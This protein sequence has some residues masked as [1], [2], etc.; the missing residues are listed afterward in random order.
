MVH[1]TLSIQ[2]EGGT[3]KYLGLPELFG[4]KKG[5]LFS[6]IVDRIKQKAMGWSN[7]FLSTAGK[8]TMLRSALSPV[9][10]YAMSC[11]QLPV[12]LCKRIQSTLTRFWWDDRMG[13]KKMAWIA[14]NKLIRPKE[15][16]G[17]DFRDIQS[18]N[19]AYLAKLTWRIIN[20]PDSLLS[21]ILLGKYCPN[22]A[23]LSVSAKSD[24]SHGWR[25]VLIGRDIVMSNASW[26]VGNG[27]SIN[28]WE[29]PWL[30]CDSQERPS[31]YRISSSQTEEIG[32]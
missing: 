15:Q 23:I 26:E 30:S 20:N 17:L 1:D 18:F 14:W 32:T 24:I 11:F 27:D 25:G 8:M 31:Q 4:R 28:I 3:G 9:P 7:R 16:G 13:S 19:E 22:E 2:K 6:S 12:S 10:S 21:R 5:D 29:K